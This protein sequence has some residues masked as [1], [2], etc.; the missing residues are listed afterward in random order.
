VISRTIYDD[1]ARKVTVIDPRGNAT[2]SEMDEL[3]RLLRVTDAIGNTLEYEYDAN[4]N[5]HSETMSEVA[6]DGKKEATRVVYDYDEQNRVVARTD[7]TNPATP[8]D[9]RFGYDQQGN[10]TSQTDP[11]GHTTRFEYDLRR[12]MTK[13][14]D[15][16][17]GVTKYVYDDAD[18]IQSVTDANQNQ[19]T[20]TYDT[21]GNL[22]TERRADGA[23]WSYTYDEN[24][25]RKTVSDPNGTVVTFIYD[26]ADRLVEKQ[27][28]VGPT[29]LI[30]KS[31]TSFQRS[32]WLKWRRQFS[33]RTRS[34][35]IAPSV[36]I[37]TRSRTVT[38][39]RLTRRGAIFRSNITTTRFLVT[40]AKA[41]S[42]IGRGSDPLLPS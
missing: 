39:I 19:T 8:L 37:S 42:P 10:M 5:K 32:V 40:L 3:G 6:P 16:M 7:V 20:F 26:D 30:M 18:R 21:E 29:S 41:T 15:A 1:A 34:W 38:R 28:A 2:V 22:L 4:N 24:F 27:I 12:R 35:M 9:T 36:S 13:K 31:T 11:D 25:N 23:T 33:S 14:T 17:G